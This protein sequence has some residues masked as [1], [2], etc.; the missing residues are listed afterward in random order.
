VP[1]TCWICV[2]LIMGP[3]VEGRGEGCG[4]QLAPWRS[5]VQALNSWYPLLTP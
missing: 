1:M 4:P 3:P 2:S 5:V